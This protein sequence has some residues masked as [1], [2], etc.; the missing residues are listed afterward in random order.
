MTLAPVNGL[1]LYYE[2]SAGSHPPLVLLHGGLLSIDLSFGDLLP[3]LAGRRTISVELQGHGRTADVVDREMSVPEMARDIVGLLDHLGVAEAD[4]FGFSLGGMVA[5]E[6]AVRFPGRVR[7]LVAAA[8]HMRPDGYHDE[9]RDPSLAAGSDRLPTEED[10]AAMAAEYRRIAPDPDH[11]DVFFARCGNAAHGWQGWSP[12]ELKAV[13]APTLV[14]V[15]DHDF[16]KV[17]HAVETTGLIHGAR[18]GVLPGT[19][20]MQL[21][22]RVDMLLPMLDQLLDG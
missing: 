6:V 3:R 21:T 17:E 11:F 4:L 12:E 2:D 8:V 7:R 14:L 10:F 1:E 13:T 5:T 19:N 20:H 18:L 9:V 16:V 22:H 15:G